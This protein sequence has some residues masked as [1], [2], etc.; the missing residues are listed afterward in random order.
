MA[1]STIE[2]RFSEPVA[3]APD[4]VELI[5]PSG[6]RARRGTPELIAGGATVRV[7]VE[8][9]TQTPRF[10][11][12]VVVWRAVS[13]DG[14]PVGGSFQFEI[15]SGTPDRQSQTGATGG[16]PDLTTVLARGLLLLGLALAVAAGRHRRWALAGV[17]TA[18][19]G[20]DE[21]LLFT[22]ALKPAQP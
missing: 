18:T 21:V 8:P 5:D 17:V 9:S 11:V 2:L 14:D 1:P 13:A 6:R 10:G 4:G 7:R 3:V 22:N 19:A 16:L 15:G 12:Y 20:L